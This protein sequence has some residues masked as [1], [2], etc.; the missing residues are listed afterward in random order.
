MRIEIP[1]RSPY[2][3]YLWLIL[4]VP[5]S[6]ITSCLKHKPLPQ[7][8]ISGK[9][10]QQVKL[11]VYGINNGDVIFRDTTYTQSAFDTLDYVEFNNYGNC[12]IGS[13]SYH[14]FYPSGA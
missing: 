10:W 11:R 12:T 9:K 6:F 3:K 2:N 4:I 14:I 7:Y 5:A 13:G 1:S 8:P